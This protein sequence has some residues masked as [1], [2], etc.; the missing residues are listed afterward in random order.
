MTDVGQRERPV[1][2]RV[3]LLFADRLG[4]HYLG[5]RQYRPGNSNIEQED[6]RT[7]LRVR[8]TNE[9]LITRA[10]H[11]LTQAA[12]LGEG[13]TLYEANR[14][15]YG[16]LRYGVKVREA[17]GE[18]TQTVQLIDW[19]KPENNDLSVAE[20]VT[21]FGN[22][23]RRPDVVLYVNGIA[24]AVLELKRSTVSVG[25]G[26]R[27]NLGNQK[28]GVIGPFFTTVQLV[29]AGNDTEGLRYGTIETAEKYYLQWRE[30]GEEPNLLDRHLTQHCNKERLLEIVHDFI[31]FDS[32]T[33]KICRHNQYF[34]VRAAQERVRSR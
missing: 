10:L 20:E 8:G 4:Y 3:V 14:E 12:A 34:G 2:D 31:V 18:P 1:Q 13:R 28:T 26:V 17:A 19:K 16:L 23:T 9:T 24:L 21:V 6:L 33:K 5:N 11:K 29:M 15:V 22:V 27:Q 25:E 7:W 30:E 32:G